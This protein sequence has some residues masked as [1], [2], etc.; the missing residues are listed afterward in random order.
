MAEWWYNNSGLN[1]L[2][3]VD[4]DPDNRLRLSDE[5]II[6]FLQTI[7][8]ARASFERLVPTMLPA[9]RDRLEAIAAGPGHFLTQDP[10]DASDAFQNRMNRMG[11]RTAGPRGGRRIGGN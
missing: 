1:L 8:E 10:K 6:A 2:K 11:V 9:E 4:G 5:Q 3:G 7:P